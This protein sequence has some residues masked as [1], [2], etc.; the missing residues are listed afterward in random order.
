ML[1]ILV[2]LG[3]AAVF[4]FHRLDSVGFLTDVP[5]S[6]SH[7]GLTR[8]ELQALPV[9]LFGDVAALQHMVSPLREENARLNDL[10]GRPTIKPSGMDK[11]TESP[12]LVVTKEKRSALLL[13]AFDLFHRRA[14]AAIQHVGVAGVG[15]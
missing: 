1:K 10:K 2:R 14:V 8:P 15:Q 6:P 4:L 12:K 11:A 5:P 3:K 9:Q 13:T 7:S